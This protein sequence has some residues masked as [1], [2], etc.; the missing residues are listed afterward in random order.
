[1]ATGT[2]YAP[3]HWQDVDAVNVSTNVTGT[4]GTISAGQTQ[5]I[6][7]LIADDVLIRGIEFLL[8]NSAFGDTVTIKVVDKDGVYSPPNTVLGT[9]VSNYNVAADQQM[10][11]SYQAVAPMKMKG[12]LY[13]R[14]TYSSTGQ[15]NVNV[16]VNFL[17]LKVLL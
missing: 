12:G 3:Q 1:M 5:N 6:D 15:I 4:T 2:T 7:T 10:Q 13:I 17:L 9:P 16:A 14:F 8:R 11:S